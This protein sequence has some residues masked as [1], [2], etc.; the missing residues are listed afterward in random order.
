MK[1]FYNKIK[2]NMYKRYARDGLE[3]KCEE[4]STALEVQLARP[5]GW[6]LRTYKTNIRR[7]TLSEKQL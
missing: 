5:T 3:K 4:R 1:I 2:C 6:F 7:H